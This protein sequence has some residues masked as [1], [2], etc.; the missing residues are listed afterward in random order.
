MNM[1][2]YF[3]GVAFEFELYVHTCTQKTE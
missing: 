3:E 2:M 1:L